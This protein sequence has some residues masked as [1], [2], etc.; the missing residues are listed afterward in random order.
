MMMG[1]Q[2]QQQHTRR[3][4][5]EGVHH[6]H[7]E[8]QAVLVSRIDGHVQE[9]EGGARPPRHKGGVA[10]DANLGHDQEHD[11]EPHEHDDAEQLQV[12][13]RAAQEVR[14]AAEAHARAADIVGGAAQDRPAHTAFGIVGATAAA[15]AAQEVTGG[16]QP[17]HM[18]LSA[19]LCCSLLT[20]CAGAVSAAPAP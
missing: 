20:V 4:R 12:L 9:G 1:G 5:D 14:D 8:Q 3:T 16:G 17:A 7:D 13:E 11:E 6:D 18:A 15:A 10:E 19:Q 2:Q